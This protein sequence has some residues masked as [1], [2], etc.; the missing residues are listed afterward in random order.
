MGYKNLF[1][2]KIILG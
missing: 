2:M 1:E